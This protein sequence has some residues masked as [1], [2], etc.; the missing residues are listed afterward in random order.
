MI[1]E[2][3]F[4]TELI[5][6]LPIAMISAIIFGQGLGMMA[7]I[8]QVKFRDLKQIVDLIVRA[9]FF[10]FRSIFWCRDYT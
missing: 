4:P 7:S 3:I 8:I 1:Y 10:S 9:G 5:I 6:L 2:Q